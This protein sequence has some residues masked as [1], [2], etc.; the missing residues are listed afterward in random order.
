MHARAS[1]R[2]T[3]TF[4]HK[5]ADVKEI[6]QEDLDAHATVQ[7]RSMTM[8]HMMITYVLHH[9]AVGTE[10]NKYVMTQMSKAVER[11]FT[12]HLQSLVVFGYTIDAKTKQLVQIKARKADNFNNYT[13]TYPH[14]NYLTHMC[15]TE[16]EGGMEIAP[17]T[18]FF[19]F[20]LNHE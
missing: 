1:D 16:F 3:V 10:H 9:R 7:Y 11:M 6:P 8:S 19:H 4:G 13:Q 2:Q 17:V 12:H 18:N 20:H 5:A 14:D 15:Y